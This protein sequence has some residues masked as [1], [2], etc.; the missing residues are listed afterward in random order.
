L[1]LVNGTNEGAAYGIYNIFL[2]PPHQTSKFIND[3][4]KTIYSSTP[5][6]SS[7]R[8]CGEDKLFNNLYI[9]W[10]VGLGVIWNFFWS[11]Q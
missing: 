3:F 10:F 7:G 9:K 1:D 8:L 11:H 2:Y 4:M 5:S 6:I